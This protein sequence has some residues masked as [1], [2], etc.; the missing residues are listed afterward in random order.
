MLNIPNN[1]EDD[2]CSDLMNPWTTITSAPK[3]GICWICGETFVKGKQKKILTISDI[4]Q[5]FKKVF[6]DENKL[7]IFESER[8]Q[9]C[10]ERY[11][12]TNGDEKLFQSDLVQN[13][14]SDWMSTL[15]CSRSEICNRYFD[16]IAE[17]SRKEKS[18]STGAMF[19]MKKRNGTGIEDCPPD[20]DC[21]NPW[22][23]LR[24]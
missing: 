1:N 5:F 10:W 16:C 11:V 4:H 3:E 17:A 22:P 19:G 7:N 15:V 14:L 20:C 24:K 23:F 18:S 21:D 2:Y 8:L 9:S 12:E 13:N 6:I